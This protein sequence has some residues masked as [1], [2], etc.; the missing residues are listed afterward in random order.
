[1]DLPSLISLAKLGCCEGSVEISSY[2][3]A[4]E[5]GTSQ[6]TASRRIQLMEKEGYITREVH[7]K[8]QRVR[9]KAKGIEALR[10]LQHD[11]EEIFSGHDANAFYLT[12]EVFSGMGEG[13][14]YMEAQGYKE[15]F[16]SKL[17]FE[18]YPG[19]LNLRLRTE[20]DVGMRQRLHQHR[21]I[22]VKGFTNG[23]RTFGSVK[24]FRANIKGVSGAVIIPER[25]HYTFDSLEFIAPVK[26]RNS[27][28]L[29]DGDIVTVKVEVN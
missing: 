1:M 8:G 18:P 24:C 13:R 16:Q 26:L 21:G 4:Q 28:G 14:Y 6:Q 22:D 3:L 5:L 29:R 19:T 9:L 2:K 27:A 10:Q 11:L 25:S 15:Q 12:G 17:G 7:P 23:N 20:E